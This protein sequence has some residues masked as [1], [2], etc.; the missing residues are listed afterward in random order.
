MPSK[1][2]LA[3]F[4]GVFRRA[5]A[6]VAVLT[7]AA[8]AGG[9]AATEG[10]AGGG[11][12]TPA[13]LRVPDEHTTV[14][15]AVDA[16]SPGD[17]V[18]VSPGTY[19]ESVLVDTDDVTVRGTDRNAVVIDGEG[20]RSSGVVA[21]ADGVRIENLTVRRTM[22]YGVLVTGMH[23]D[24][25]PSAHGTDGYERLDPSRFPP[26]E[27]FAVRHVTAA[28]NGLYG[29]YAFDARHGAITDS[30]ASG[31]A[32][33]GIYVGQCRECDI[34]VQG[35]VAERNAVGFENANASDSVVVSGN[36]FSANRVGMTFLSNYQEAF[37]PQRAGTVVGNV[38]TTNTSADSP[39][40]AE[41][42][43]G[44]G[45]GISGGRHNVLR[46]NL[47]AGNPRAGVLLANTEDLAAVGNRVDGSWAGDGVSRN[48]VDIANVSADRAPAR[49]TCPGAAASTLPENLRAACGT[50]GP[51]DGVAPGELPRVQ[52]PPGM[53][54]LEVPAP[55]PQ[56][57]M[58]DVENV[59]APLPST[60]T[61]GI[62]LPEG[63]PDADLLAERSGVA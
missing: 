37:T 60:V 23:D 61:A 44:I 20:V 50:P 14:Q 28:N 32:D 42:A 3:S 1:R 11:D 13:V 49:G 9:S 6:A 63:V 51:L 19:A 25:G 57:G 2:D 56:P 7:V 5:A 39:A 4:I 33:S 41:G 36:R 17:L 52:A 59:P 18:L 27:R 38:V 46:D 21:T 55:P 35:N 58:T 10:T 43:F 29:I 47:V 24:D 22:H 62:R 16:A 8:C 15:A 40:H 45:I 31:S 48:G 26:V 54:F 53:S 12:G 30:Y 34:L